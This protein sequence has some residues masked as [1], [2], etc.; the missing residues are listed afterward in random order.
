MGK[1]A[2]S[3][4]RPACAVK[5]TV[6]LLLSTAL[7]GWLQLAQP[8][9]RKTYTIAV[10]PYQ[11]SLTVY[12]DWA[13]L[14]E[15]LSRRLNAEFELKVYQAFPQFEL[16]VLRGHVDFVF[17]NPYHQVMAY[18]AHGYVPLAR[19]GRG[20]T[21]FLIV[22]KDSSIRTVEDLADKTVAFPAPRAF[23]AY[24]NVLAQLELAQ[25][26]KIRIV[27][28]FVESHNEIY[29]HVILGKVDAGGGILHTLSREPNELRSQ[30]RILYE[31]PKT[32]SHAFAAHPRVPVAVRRAVI[33]E[34][35]DLDRSE[36]GRLLLERLQLA[37]PV[38]AD[39]AR[40][41]QP[42]E[43]LKLERFVVN[44]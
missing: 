6:V 30:L 24:L 16:D 41:Y 22:R 21:G 8:R 25:Q 20:L 2:A 1:V 13:P 5:W 35:L 17:M 44:R 36:S 23:G 11:L 37:E 31:T 7:L 3:H 19:T 43:R 15:H 12:K 28:R 42:L 18:K 27:P 9:E 38:A 39:Y 40:D 29:R 26:K 14:T 32:V 33:K 4:T 34:I 10:V